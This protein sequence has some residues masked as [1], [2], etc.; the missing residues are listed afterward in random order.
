CCRSWARR[1]SSSIASGSGCVGSWR[2]S[3]R[4]HEPDNEIDRAA[5]SDEKREQPYR[6]SADQGGDGREANR[7]LQGGDDIRESLVRTEVA[8]G[9]VLQLGALHLELVRLLLQLFLP[10]LLVGDAL[11]RLLDLL[12]RRLERAEECDLRLGRRGLDPLC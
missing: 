5:Q 12:R 10:A 11:T 2:S 8:D 1:A 6:A 9:V 7:D 4:L 3:A